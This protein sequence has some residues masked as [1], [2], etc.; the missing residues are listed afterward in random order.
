MSGLMHTI[1]YIKLPIVEVY[2]IFVISSCSF[3]LPGH[4]SNWVESDTWGER[5]HLTSSHVESLK[6]FLHAFFWDSQG[7]L[8][9]LFLVIFIPRI[10]M[11]SPKSFITNN[12]LSFVFKWI[13]IMGNH[14]NGFKCM[15]GIAH[16]PQDISFP[17]YPSFKPCIQ[18]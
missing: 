5:W 6:N 12:L 1:T 13:K 8:F 4:C 15:H 11:G 10:C 17:T 18:N 16:K 9:A 14:N 3:S 2:D 7:F